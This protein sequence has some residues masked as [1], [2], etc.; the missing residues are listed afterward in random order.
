M[1]DQS[2]KKKLH[3][4]TKTDMCGRGLR[5]PQER[6]PVTSSDFLRKAISSAS[7]QAFTCFDVQM[8]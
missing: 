5:R 1:E 8:I 2:V 6:K 3:F 7:I 4:Q